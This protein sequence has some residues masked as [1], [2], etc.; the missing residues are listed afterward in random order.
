MS[1]SG[2]PALRPALLGAGAGLSYA[3]FV[4]DLV[5][6][7]PSSLDHAVSE[8]AAPG[9][10]WAWF[11]RAAEVG[12]AAA[13]LPLLPP[14]RSAL[15]PG[16]GREVVTGATAVF[17]VAAAAAGVVPTPC[18]PG[19]AWGVVDLR[20]RS[21]L[22]D[23]ASLLA[24]SAAYVGVGAAWATTRRRG[25][26]WFHRA[27]GWTLLVGVGSGLVHGA[28]RS[29]AERRRVSGVS[30]RVDVLAVSAWLG[31]LGVLGAQAAG[32]TEP[33]GAPR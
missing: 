6:R 15:P 27:A 1:G 2:R 25:P 23:A 20:P 30:Q 16:V 3:T 28:T 14:V 24:E 13:V 9:E 31:C 5:R 33:Q 4:V 8:L 21:D 26:R 22:H 29:H 12:C 10:R 18:G 17:A 11:Y 7:G 19:L 32:T